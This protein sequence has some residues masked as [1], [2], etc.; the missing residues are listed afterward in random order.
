MNEELNGILLT[1][2]FYIGN[3]VPCPLKYSR[4]PFPAGS[5]VALASYAVHRLVKIAKELWRSSCRITLKMLNRIGPSNELCGALLVTDLQPNFVPQITNLFIILSMRILQWAVFI[6]WS[7]VFTG[8][9]SVNS[10]VLIVN[11]H[12]SPPIHQA[13]QFMREGYQVVWAWV[14]FCSCQS[15][16]GCYWIAQIPLSSDYPV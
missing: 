9:F 11:A 14:P 1:L 3:F 7:I 8:L 13:S 5:W 12:C 4:I 2:K 15:V 16:A 6:I 10:Q